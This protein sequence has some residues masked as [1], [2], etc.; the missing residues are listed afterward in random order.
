MAHVK[1]GALFSL[2]PNNVELGHNL[3]NSALRQISAGSQPV[4]AITP[5]KDVLVAVNVR[6]AGHLGLNIGQRQQQAFDMVFP[7]P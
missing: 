6:T 3:A 2:Y 5:L 4:N 1:R 7:E